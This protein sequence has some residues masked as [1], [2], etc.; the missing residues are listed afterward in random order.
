MALLG[1]CARRSTK[2]NSI[3]STLR[4]P[5]TDSAFLED[6]AHRAFLYFWEQGDPNTGLVRDRALA[7]GSPPPNTDRYAASIAATGF[8]LTAL[9][10]A[11]DHRWEDE[12]RLRDRAYNTLRYFAYEAP[13]K[14]GFFYH[15]LD[16]S[17]G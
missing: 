15:W 17:T 6:V 12:Q 2:V 5:V 16:P 13:G 3:V 7:D 10:I 4:L 8:G 1:G 11:A 9:A 14:N